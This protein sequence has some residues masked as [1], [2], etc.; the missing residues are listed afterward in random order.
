[1][2]LAELLAAIGEYQESMQH[3]LAAKYGI[4]MCGGRDHPA[5]GEL[6][7]R[8]ADVC[9]VGALL[10]PND[11]YRM[12]VIARERAYTYHIKAAIGISLGTYLDQNNAS[13]Q[14]YAELNQSFRIM[15]QLYGEEDP[16][17]QEAKTAMLAVKRKFVQARVE[18]QKSQQ[19]AL[20]KRT[21]L[22]KEEYIK[23]QTEA[24]QKT[25]QS[26]IAKRRYKQ[27]LENARSRAG[28]R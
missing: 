16:K 10:D 15:T 22:L 13:E 5:L 23:K 28:R 3:Y 21:Q 24:L 12:L 18:A 14:A 17:T 27:A 2:K 4:I 11:V 8:M 7:R 25:Q 1:M 26:E 6:L 20:E 19:E 9:R